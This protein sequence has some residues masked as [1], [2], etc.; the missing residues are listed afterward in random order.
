MHAGELVVAVVL[1]ERELRASERLVVLI[2]LEDGKPDVRG[3]VVLELR[4]IGV[5]L[6]DYVELAS[7]GVSTF[8]L[9]V[10]VWA[11]YV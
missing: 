4:P 3:V 10:S 2:M 6:S 1:V 9:T 7:P 5:I 11:S 8:T